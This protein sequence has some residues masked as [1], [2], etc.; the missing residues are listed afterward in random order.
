[1]IVWVFVLI[2]TYM[3]THIESIMEK[4]QTQKNL[5][6]HKCYDVE[7]YLCLSVLDINRI[8]P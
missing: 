1:M 4:K 2:Y 3:H 5:K 6:M 7:K 8:D